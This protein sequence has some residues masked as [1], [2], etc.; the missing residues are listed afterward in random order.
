MVIRM[1]P[2]DVNVLKT[3]KTYT[4]SWDMSAIIV[5]LIVKSIKNIFT[6]CNRYTYQIK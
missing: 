3:M 5:L 2:I 6:N 4:I 1:K